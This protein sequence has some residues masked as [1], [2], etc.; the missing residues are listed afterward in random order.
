[1]K[2]I[3]FIN[4]YNAIFEVASILSNAK[5][6]SWVRADK[7]FKI[8]NRDMIKAFC[9]MKLMFKSDADI[10][11]AVELLD[12]AFQYPDEDNSPKC[13]YRA[14]DIFKKLAYDSPS[15]MGEYIWVHLR[16]SVLDAITHHRMVMSRMLSC[17]KKE[18]V[19]GGRIVACWEIGNNG[20]F[21][22]EVTG[23]DVDEISEKIFSYENIL[24]VLNT[25]RNTGVYGTGNIYYYFTVYGPDGECLGN[26]FSDNF[27]ITEDIFQLK[28]EKYA[29]K[30]P[31]SYGGKEFEKDNNKK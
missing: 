25:I 8:L 20:F 28:M 18:L 7:A 3:N 31:I 10:L 4:A 11:K 2:K 1:M 21:D 27:N 29:S 17:A 19:K 30:I 9:V 15:D 23:L 24:W 6:D 14:V 16:P 13:F 22:E 26:A 12:Y 5:E